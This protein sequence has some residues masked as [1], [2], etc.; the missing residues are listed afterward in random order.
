MKFYHILYDI[1]YYMILYYMK[2]Y[3]IILDLKTRYTRDSMAIRV[4]PVINFSLIIGINSLN[5]VEL[6]QRQTSSTVHN[7]NPI[8][9][10]LR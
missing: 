8:K 1:L 6:T 9:I 5:P 10:K 4:R 3:I 7:N 2:F